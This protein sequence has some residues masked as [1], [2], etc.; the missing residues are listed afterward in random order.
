MLES[1]MVTVLE[2]VPSVAWT[3]AEVFWLIVWQE[4]VNIA[5]EAPAVTVTLAGTV[6]RLDEELTVTVVF[7]ET[8][9]ES[10][11]LQ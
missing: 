8:L 3:T 7:A 2:L 10:V 5:P 4:M 11:T 1:V 9:C 6:N